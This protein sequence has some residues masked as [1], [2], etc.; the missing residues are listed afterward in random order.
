MRKT[1][2]A[3]RK[4]DGLLDEPPDPTSIQSKTCQLPT[5]FRDEVGPGRLPRLES[6][7]LKSEL[8]DRANAPTAELDF[9][10]RFRHNFP[11]PA[12]K[13]G[14]LRRLPTQVGAFLCRIADGSR[15]D[16]QMRG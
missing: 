1:H 4:S 13:E 8:R 6:R 12:P 9:G 5:S 16:E 7:G 3:C 14:A 15:A 2:P 10:R 11:L